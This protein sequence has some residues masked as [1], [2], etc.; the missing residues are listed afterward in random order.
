MG[1]KG[2]AEE[3]S[4]AVKLVEAKKIYDDQLRK[5]ALRKDTLSALKEQAHAVMDEKIRKCREQTGNFALRFADCAELKSS[6]GVA[7][8]FLEISDEGATG[9]ATGGTTG[10]ATGSEL[11]TQDM[12]AEEEKVAK[13]EAAKEKEEKEAT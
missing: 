3:E 1:A 13:E 2:K 5:A 8:A 4:V 11:V 10:A 6:F 12:K 7:N 9:T